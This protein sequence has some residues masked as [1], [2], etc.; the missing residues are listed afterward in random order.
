ME[1]YWNDLRRY[2]AKFQNPGKS[3]ISDIKAADQSARG[4][5]KNEAL[6]GILKAVQMRIY[7]VRNGDLVPIVLWAMSFTSFTE[8]AI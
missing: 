1:K 4:A 8:A 2:K 3:G 6:A 5:L 7:M